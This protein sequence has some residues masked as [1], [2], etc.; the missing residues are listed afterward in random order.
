MIRPLAL[1]VALIASG[2]A[3]AQ[4]A[5]PAATAPAAFDAA[6]VE[7]RVLTG[8]TRVAEAAEAR[9]AADPSDAGAWAELGRAL[10]HGGRPYAGLVCYTRAL[11]LDPAATAGILDRAFGLAV[12]LGEDAWLGEALLNAFS[13][14]MS[15]QT[16]ARLALAVARH[17]FR[18]GSWG[19]ALGLLPLIPDDSELGLDAVVLRSTILA[20]QQ[21]YTDALP[22]ALTAVERARQARRSD[23]YV[24]TL[25]MNAARTLF[26]A[27][28][29]EQAEGYYDRVPRSDPAWPRAQVEAAWAHFR[30]DDMDGTLSRLQTHDSPFFDTF[31][32]PEASMLR[33]QALYLLCKFPDTT[34]AI[35][36]FQT[37]YQPL[38]DALRATLPGLDPATAIAQARAERDGADTLLPRAL[39][40]NTRWDGRLDT[41]IRALRDGRHELKNLEIMPAARAALAERVAAREA[42][43]GQRLLDQLTAQRDE[44]ADLLSNIELTRI[45]LLS[46]QSELYQRAAA[47]GALPAPAPDARQ[48]RRDLRRAG[49]RVWPFEGEYW[50]DELGSYRVRTRPEC[51]DSL[52]RGS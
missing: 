43:E 12:E 22:L 5:P 24:A 20:Q 16:R 30:R 18:E 13:A 11:R 48:A 51:P 37:R 36:A 49:K 28:S 25:A 3:A 52:V 19:D 33:A 44:L 4:D 9:L 41:A 39:L 17:H 42:V 10:E 23:R 21:R 29:F 6:A 15:A 46:L 45:D 38:L 2:P 34:A 26:A 47:G 40:R 31:Y 50:V 27:G 14:P 1:A 8:W 7:S 32:L 35:D